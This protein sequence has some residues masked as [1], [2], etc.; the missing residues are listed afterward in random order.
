M[1]RQAGIF[2]LLI[3]MTF[4]CIS[5]F[6]LNNN[7][8]N[9]ITA[10]HID[11][12]NVKAD[13]AVNFSVDQTY[14]EMRTLFLMKDVEFITKALS[15]FKYNFA[16]EL[17]EKMIQD[18]TIGLSCDEKVTV[19]YGMI[20]RSCPKKNVQYEWLDLLL[21]YP[22]LHAQN[23]VLLTLARSRYA[24]NIALFIAWGKDR[25]KASDRMG[26]LAHCATQAFKKAVEDNDYTAVETL[27]SKKVRI[28]PSKAS[29]L[30][31]YI[32]E[33]GKSSALISLLVNH[34]QANVNCIA[35]G[36]TLLMVA[37]ENNNIEIIRALLDR[38]AVVDRIIDG[39]KNTALMIATKKKYR[40]VEQLLREYG[41]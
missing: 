15:Q 32:V 16:R 23:P 27:F 5:I 9:F 12:C 10:T 26:L 37:V 25:Q 40:S 33:A 31:W 35:N 21:E 13:L 17:I 29:E 2:R 14:Q 30:L 1:E 36:K 41:A 38:G 39:E 19:I 6:F 18:E 28:T 20:T 34:A 8:K 4:F 7:K 11:I 3:I 24:D 22:L